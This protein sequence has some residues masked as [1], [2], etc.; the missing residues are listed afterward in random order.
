LQF[1]RQDIEDLAQK[2]DCANSDLT[3]SERTLLLAIFSAASEHVTLS[4]PASDSGQ[5]DVTVAGLTQQLINSFIPSPDNEEGPFVIT[6][7]EAR[8]SP[9]PIKPGPNPNPDPNPDPNPT[10]TES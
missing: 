9:G 7:R 3:D 2:L 1:S 8:I 6:L 5:P 10:P 4:A